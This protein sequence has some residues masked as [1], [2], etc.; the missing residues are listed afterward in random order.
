[1]KNFNSLQVMVIV[2]L[3]LFHQGCALDEKSILTGD[4][5]EQSR[6][7]RSPLG[8]QQAA[9]TAF[10]EKVKEIDEELGVRLLADTVYLEDFSGN[11][12][13]LLVLYRDAE[14]IPQRLFVWSLPSRTE[15]FSCC[16]SE[17]E[18][19]GVKHKQQECF[20]A[21]GR[22]QLWLDEQGKSLPIIDTGEWLDRS[23]TMIN[24]A[25]FYLGNF[26]K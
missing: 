20:F 23:N 15:E 3:A 26:S 22:M 14:N 6:T 2:A 9:L 8:D 5:P 7:M 19:M 16:Y 1:M 13:K 21:K 25:E 12:E 11:E 4:Y 10:R 18:L 24:L 17:G